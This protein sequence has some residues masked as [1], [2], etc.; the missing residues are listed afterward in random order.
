VGD[1]ELPAGVKVAPAIALIQQSAEHYPAPEEFRPERFLGGRAESYA[2]IPFGGGIRRCLG[3]SFAQLEMRL[4]LSRVLR[5]ARLEPV[6]RRPERAQT[7]NIT[8]VPGR[9][10]RVRLLERTSNG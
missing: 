3:A 6:G 10:V 4:V 7:R 2:W 8:S 9:G 1:Y 5:R